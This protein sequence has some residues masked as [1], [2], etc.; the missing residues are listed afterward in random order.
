MA[1]IFSNDYVKLI[2]TD[3]LNQVIGSNANILSSCEAAAEA[4]AKSY[5]KMKYDVDSEF[6]D[7]S[8]WD[9][10]QGYKA[11][12]RVYLDADAYL[13][14]STYNTNDLTLHDGK[15]YRANQDGITGTWDG[16]KWNLEGEQYTLYYAKFPQPKFDLYALYKKG[17]SVFYNNK[18]YVCQADSILPDHDSI[19]QA[20]KTS[21][22]PNYNA[23]PGTSPQWDNG[24]DYSVPSASDINTDTY[25][26]KGD[27]RD[28]M[29]LQKVIDI[30]LYHVHTRITPKNIPEIRIVR[31]MGKQEDRGIFEKRILYPTY[32][33]LGWLQAAARNED[34][35][36]GIPKK[37]PKQGFRVLYSGN[38]KQVNSY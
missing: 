13:D 27:N 23:V 38:V 25:W 31:Y 16:T 6:T 7:T 14:A 11:A 1:Y 21:A 3:N 20:G 8:K 19:I 34:I 37:Q 15:V 24:T 32:S 36:P 17:D 28:Q 9:Y 26:I 30:C 4:E 33:A 2:Q 18:V 22:I 35:E 5:L 12:D 10:T 29:L